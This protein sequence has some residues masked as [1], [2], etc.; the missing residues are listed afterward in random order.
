MEEHGLKKN[1]LQIRN[2]AHLKIIRHYTREA[3]VRGLERQIA[4]ICRKAAKLLVSGEKK[5]VIITE[6]NLSEFLGKPKYRY[7]QAE[8]EDQ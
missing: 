3:G 4:A 5:R 1:Q 8:L 7:G 6:N 2:E